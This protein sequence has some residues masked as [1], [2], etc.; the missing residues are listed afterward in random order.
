MELVHANVYTDFY[1]DDLQKLFC[2]VRKKRTNKMSVD[3]YKDICLLWLELLK[4]LRPE[5]QIVDDINME[6]IITP[7]L[8][9][10][11]IENLIIPGINAGLKKV[12][13][14]ESI[15]AFSKISV[16][17]TM[18]GY[19]NDIEINFFDNMESA[20]KWIQVDF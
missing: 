9:Q 17:Q 18:E 14:V 2:V 3:E 5:K 6:F 12:A 1:F 10:W 15:D 20:K 4:R 19:P 11:A 13:F 16:E 8:Q 7:E